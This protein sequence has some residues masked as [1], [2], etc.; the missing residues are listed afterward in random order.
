MSAPFLLPRGLP[1]KE[2]AAYVG[3]SLSR[4]DAM[5]RDGRIPE[6]VSVTL[7]RLYFGATIISQ[8]ESV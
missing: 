7:T 4:F 3:V 2:A 6:L 5:V 1:R 8:E